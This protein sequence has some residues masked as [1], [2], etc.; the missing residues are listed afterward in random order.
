MVLPVAAVVVHAV[1]IVRRRVRARG[2]VRRGR[3]GVGLEQCPTIAGG[4]AVAV[5]QVSGMTGVL[6]VEELA[7]G[8]E[9]VETIGHNQARTTLRERLLSRTCW[10]GLLAVEE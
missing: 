10:S 2:S 3:V 6:V 1:V 5:V 8:I 9:P 7:A 4:R